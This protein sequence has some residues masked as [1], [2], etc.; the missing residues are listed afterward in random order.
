MRDTRDSD[1]WYRAGKSFGDK[2]KV[3]SGS[4]ENKRTKLVLEEAVEDRRE[5]HVPTEF[6]NNFDEGLKAGKEER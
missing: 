6:I 4:K 1:F 3:M 5:N 2:I